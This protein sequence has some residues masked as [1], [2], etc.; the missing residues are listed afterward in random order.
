MKDV[1]P[2]IESGLEWPHEIRVPRDKNVLRINAK[3]YKIPQG[4]RS[5]SQVLLATPFLV[6]YVSF[7]LVV[8]RT[9]SV[10]S[11]PFVGQ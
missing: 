8:N 9:S 10:R 4:K 2:T 11:S 1:L 3:L 7:I 6:F 5:R